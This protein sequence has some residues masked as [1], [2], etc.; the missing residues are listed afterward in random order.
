MS[1][2]LERCYS[3]DKYIYVNSVDCEDTYDECRDSAT[4]DYG[5]YCDDTFYPRCYNGTDYSCV[6]GD[7]CCEEIEMVNCDY[8]SGDVPQYLQVV[9]SGVTDCG[10]DA[11]GG[12]AVSCESW[13]NATFI[14]TF[15][16]GSATVC[17]WR[18]LDTSFQV[19]VTLNASGMQVVGGEVTYGICITGINNSCLDECGGH[20]T[21][22]NVLDC[23]GGTNEDAC[24]G[25]NGTAII[26]PY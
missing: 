1:I 19:N 26:T 4:G 22:N 24:S 10:A 11:C 8:C 2:T 13:I 21:V 5:V 12:G 20:C 17:N 25:E 16:N 7:E 18:Y 6:V 14:A 15:L 23:H 9:I 3:V